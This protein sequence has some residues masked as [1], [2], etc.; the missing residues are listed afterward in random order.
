MVTTTWV[1]VLE[2]YKLQ[3]AMR[4][5]LLGNVYKILNILDIFKPYMH[6]FYTCIL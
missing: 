6:R 4:L 2:N 5:L 3:Y 1:D